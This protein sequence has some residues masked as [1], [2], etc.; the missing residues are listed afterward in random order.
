MTQRIKIS[1]FLT[2]PKIITPLK[3]TSI[4]FNLILLQLFTRNLTNHSETLQNYL[5]TPQNLKTN[6]IKQT[7]AKTRGKNLYKNKNVNCN[8]TRK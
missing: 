8:I 3:C 2:R 4:T 5:H 7:I 6:T 1:V